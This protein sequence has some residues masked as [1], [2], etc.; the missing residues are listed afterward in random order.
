MGFLEAALAEVL[1]SKVLDKTEPWLSEKILGSDKEKAFK[2]C[3]S[4]GI[5]AM[6]EHIQ[7]DD[8]DMLTHVQSVLKK[9]FQD[10]AIVGEMEKLLHPGKQ[11]DT[12][13]L[14]SIFEKTGDP[15][16][17]P[18]DSLDQAL[19]D[20]IE[21][22]EKAANQ[23]ES[24]QNERIISILDDI[25][26]LQF[27]TDWESSYLNTLISRCLVLDLS[28]ID[29]STAGG[30]NAVDR[31][32]R[33]DHVFT[34][35]Y[36]E[37]LSRHPQQSVK[38]VITRG[39][40]RDIPTETR[41]KKLHRRGLTGFLKKQLIPGVDK[42][43]ISTGSRPEE[44]LLNQEHERLPV[45]A[46]E[47]IGAMDRLVVL[48][49][50]GGGKSTLVNY[51]A[52]QLAF[53]RS[54]SEVMP[55]DH[56]EDPM[57][58]WA[59][60]LKYLPVRIVLR[61]FAAWLPADVSRGDAGHVWDYLKSLLAQWGCSDSFTPLRNELRM[62]GGVIFFDGLD[63]VSETDEAA[64]RT[65]IKEAI[66]AF[67]DPLKHCKI[68]ITCRE[69]AYRV[70]ASSS[71]QDSW[72]LPRDQFPIVNLALFDLEQIKL[73]CQTWYR[74]VGPFLHWTEEKNDAEATRLSDAIAGHPHLLELAQYPLLLTL[75]AQ[76]HGRDGY[77][78]E[79]RADLYGRSLELLLSLWDNRLIRDE[80]GGKS[81][82]QGLVMRL[83]IRADKLR[84]ML[85]EVAFKAHER[86]ELE[87]SRSEKAANLSREELRQAIHDEVKDWNKAEEALAFI[88][89]R[90]GLLVARDNQT[91]A[92]PHRTYQEYLAARHVLHQPDAG[93]MLRARVKRD[94]QWWR[95]VYLLAAGD[96][97]IPANVAAQV[98]ALLPYPP[99]PERLTPEQI[100]YAKLAAQAL[101]ESGF[102]QHVQ[103]ERAKEPGHFSAT[104]EKVQQWL[105]A[106]MRATEVLDAKARA[107]AGQVL[108]RL[109]DPRLEVLRCE[110]MQFCRI[111][112]GSFLMGGTDEDEKA[113]DDEKPQHRVEL[114]YDYW[115]G[116]YPVTVAQFRQY[117]EETGK[118]PKNPESLEGIA[119]HPVVNVTWDEAIY[120]CRWLSDR[121]QEIAAERLASGML[122]EDER[123]L[124]EGLAKDELR[125]TLPREAE[126]EKAARGMDDGRIYSWGDTWDANRCNSSD[127]GIGKT[128]SV[129]CFPNGVRPD[130]PVEE[131]IG[132]VLEWCW[133]WYDKNLYGQRRGAT[134]KDPVGPESGPA[135][136]L[137]GGSFF[138]D[139][140]DCRCA[141]RV[142]YDPFNHDVNWGF[143][144]VVLPSTMSD[145][146][147]A[148]RALKNDR[149]T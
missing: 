63:E 97:G 36:L 25:L 16:Q 134:V 61:R 54:I 2:R 105:L 44:W 119:N 121:L 139:R 45:Q 110:A 46:V 107:E 33:V 109:G 84:A 59:P 76:L 124:W 101:W 129:G 1:L 77:L 19:I 70:K 11:P 5:T 24:L 80:R 117:V 8:L 67:A 140:Q 103:K 100:D 20:F 90:A 89:N 31:K 13:R 114:T 93:E 92:F 43:D 26:R 39:E 120:F 145:E 118:E 56:A 68:I 23:E 48:G 102:E 135:R 12:D 49:H 42:T 50:P 147:D 7:T 53:R 88:Q 78:P 15:A 128:S 136:V 91:Y 94:L 112:K 131:M 64:K 21:G 55:G 111:P 125:A 146:P 74:T 14:K 127:T 95:E 137:R 87:A 18:F 65:L 104:F 37:N 126:W 86:Q 99:M 38:E 30:A 41:G 9:Y 17:L 52:V 72:V 34:R 123:L 122:E 132:N 29:F 60:T 73:F 96:V 116:K 3:Y 35:L 108:S 141:A 133:D 144:V 142:L 138:S 71:R 51:L 57:P 130:F 83:G 148:K 4:A 69:Y 28:Q 62:R 85:A 115:I 143:R 98:N 106:G 82:E 22:F 58:G 47:A 40:N 32:I 66:E 10:V 79:D 6:L 149:R 75:M 27:D 113:S 81:V